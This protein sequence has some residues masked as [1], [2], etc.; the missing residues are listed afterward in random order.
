MKIIVIGLGSMGRRRIR[1]LQQYDASLEIIGVDTS[2]IRAEEAEQELGIVCTASIEKALEQEGID[3]AFVC[4]SPLSHYKIAKTLLEYNLNV[5]TEINLVAD[6]YQELINLSIQ[7]K[8][9]LFLSSTFLYRKDIQYMIRRSENERVNYIYH[10]GQFLPDWHPW[11]NYK[12]FFVSEKRTNGCREIMAI[13]FPWL[14]QCFGRIKNIHVI[15]DNMSS[16]ELNYYDNYLLSIEHENGNKGIIGVDVVSRLARRTLEIYGE[17][18]QLFWDGAPD[19]LREYD[20]ETKTSNPVKTYD[21]IT[22]DTHYCDNIIENAY[23]DEIASFL[24][25]VRSGMNDKTLYSF[26]QDTE[27][28]RW[29]DKVENEVLQ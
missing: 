8:R 4:T 26:E 15:K 11:E 21:N 2:N 27:T 6:G 5:F 20:I 19:S 14:I 16:L 10:T 12:D 3:C 28:L 1:L 18:V 23:M 24:Y 9:V 13:E 25:Q 29:I 22:K 17:H 7:H